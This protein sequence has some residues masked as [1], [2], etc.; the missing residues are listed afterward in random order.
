MERLLALAEHRVQWAPERERADALL[1]ELGF[2]GNDGELTEA[3]NDYY[4]AR[5]V[6]RK[7]G[8]SAEAL[9]DLLKNHI[10]PSTFCGSLWGTG[11]IGKKGA[12]SLVARITRV[13][14]DA[15]AKRWLELMNLARMI[16]YNRNNPNIRILYNPSELTPP[17]EGAARERSRGHVLSP[18][19]PY[20]NLLALRELI[21]SSREYIRWYEPHMPPKV[22]EV[23]IKEV[24][25][26]A[27]D[28]LRIL[29]GP[30]HVT[31]DLKDEFKRFHKEMHVARGVS[32]AWRV[33]SKKEA[34]KRHDRFFLSEGLTRNLPP[35]NTILAGSTGEILDSDIDV[36]Q[37]DK[38]WALGTDLSG[39]E[40][41]Q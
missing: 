19:T 7:S 40:P 41:E 17:E 33:L 5:W 12:V 9:A 14:D 25:G 26:S 36:S 18:E 32:V 34:F 27:L 3:G 24:D 22:L 21:R 1:S 11:G 16:S 28:E 38:W 29:S 4:F 37:F 2:I 13:S 8:R 20:S 31:E 39:F 15:S 6:T 30:S 10:V 35:L 23:L